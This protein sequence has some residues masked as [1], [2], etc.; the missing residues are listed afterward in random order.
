M[1]SCAIKYC[2]LE[3]FNS[4]LWVLPKRWSWWPSVKTQVPFRRFEVVKNLSRFEAR[5]PEERLTG[6]EKLKVSV[7]GEIGQ[8]LRGQ[9]VRFK[10]VGLIPVLGIEFGGSVAK[11]KSRNLWKKKSRKKKRKKWS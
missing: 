5:H 4:F 6:A 7:A 1:P 8:A 9:A 11:G 3:V 10:V 2:F